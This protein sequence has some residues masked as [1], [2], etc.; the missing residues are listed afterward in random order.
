MQQIVNT[1]RDLAL[2][3]CDLQEYKSCQLCPRRCQANR[4]NARGVCHVG[5]KLLVAR[6]ALHMWEEPCISGEKGS[7]AVFFSGCQLGCIFCQNRDIASGQ[8]G[9]QITMKRL[10]EIFWELRE[11][12]ANNI[13]LVT[14]DHYL[15]SIIVAIEKVKADGF[16]LPFVY[17]CSGYERV[18]LLR[19]LEGLISVYLP[20]FKYMQAETARA[21]SK[22]ADYP[23]VAKEAIAEMV[24][25]CPDIEF[26]ENG[27]MMQ[28][29][30]VRHLLLP[31]KVKE[32]KEIVAYLY[33]NYGSQIYLSLM[34]QYTP[35]S[36]FAQYPQLSRKVTKREYQRLLDYVLELGVE[37]AFIQEE[38][39]AKE[40]FIP[41]FDYEGV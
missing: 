7:G 23:E 15:P 17:N 36:E 10:A 30:I 13:N 40:S 14:P 19:R 4:Q 34:S 26:D 27:I 31:G 9:K 16:D 2:G 24:R 37:N 33:E 11:K 28:G 8:V 29:V 18:E 39:V 1:P 32:A 25:Q 35:L 3:V 12:G 22:A 5:D 41:A 20:D 38:D 21:Y 6:A